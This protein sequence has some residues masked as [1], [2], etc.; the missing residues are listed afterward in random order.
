MA[1]IRSIKPEFWKDGKIGRMSDSCALFFIGLWNFC[2]DEGKC[3]NDS[4]ELA[5]NMP[6]FKS[7]HISKWIQTLF[8]CGSIQL[9]V[10]FKWISITNWNHQKIDKPRLPSVL[11]KD[12]EWLQPLEADLSANARRL[13]DDNSGNVRRKDRIGE[14]RIGDTSGRTNQTVVDKFDFESLY[15]LYPK[16]LGDVRK[17]KGFGILKA[18]IKTQEDFETAI[19]AVKAYRDYCNEEKITNTSKVRMLP[20]FFDSLGD[21]KEWANSEQAKKETSRRKFGDV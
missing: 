8:E 13:F 20:S 9:S 19:K 11:K 12:I 1:R 18:Q 15:A 2:D 17:G 4:F 7:Q 10:D 6:R 3:K 16:R 21:W 5:S 14:D